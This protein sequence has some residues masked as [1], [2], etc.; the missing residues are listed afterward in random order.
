MNTNDFTKGLFP[1]DY[2][3]IGFS[4]PDENNNKIINESIILDTLGSKNALLEFYNH[5]GKFGY[6]DGILNE[7]AVT[8][9]E[10]GSL[11]STCTAET[12]SILAV[13]KESDDEDYKIYT[14]CVMLM[15][16]CME[17]MKTK[18]CNIAKER[19]ETQKTIIDSNPRVQ[20]AIEKVQDN[21]PV[22]SI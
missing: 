12:S 11:G 8:D 20:D 1:T 16:K 21:A 4:V 17:N 5:I 2:S 10:L 15:Q 6:R 22:P 7:S 19:L 18:Y 9:I 14:K 13:A 3:S